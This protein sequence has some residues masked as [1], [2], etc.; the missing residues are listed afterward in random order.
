M[1][2]FS[3]YVKANQATPAAIHDSFG[4]RAHFFEKWNRVPSPPA[5][6]LFSIDFFISIVRLFIYSCLISAFDFFTMLN[7]SPAIA[8]MDS[9]H[10]NF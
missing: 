5:L 2:N 7:V 6:S 10:S 9:D 1:G 4:V 3:K 8:G